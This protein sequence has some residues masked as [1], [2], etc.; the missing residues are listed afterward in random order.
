MVF[1]RRLLA[2]KPPISAPEKELPDPVWGATF[3]AELHHVAGLMG[4]TGATEHALRKGMDGRYFSTALSR[5]QKELKSALGLAVH[6]YLIDDG[7]VRPRRYAL[8]LPR[9]AV[10]IVSDGNFSLNQPG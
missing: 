2:G 1:V 6:P 9:D 3:L 4:D 5:L 10:Q 7:G 8:T